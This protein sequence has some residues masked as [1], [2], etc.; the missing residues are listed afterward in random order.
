MTHT[1]A[2]RS[3]SKTSYS[4]PSRGHVRS[5]SNVSKVS[6]KFNKSQRCLSINIGGPGRHRFT[7]RAS[8][9]YF[10][11]PTTVL[12]GHRVENIS[13]SPIG[14]RYKNSTRMS[15]KRRAHSTKLSR[16][17]AISVGRK[18]VTKSAKSKGMNSIKKKIKRRVS[19]KKLMRLMKGQ[20]SDGRKIKFVK[21][22][23]VAQD[24]WITP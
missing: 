22:P 4:N 12:G 2:T 20:P 7:N 6:D 11:Q 8:S 1:D 17:R 5:H 23:P 19:I 3:L 21:S 16:N 14:S 10:G 15:K 24:D 9:A 13:V 18:S